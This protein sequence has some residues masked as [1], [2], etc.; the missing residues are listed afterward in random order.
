MHSS[1]SW[2]QPL[3][4]RLRLGI[5]RPSCYKNI[6]ELELQYTK[7]GDTTVDAGPHKTEM[8]RL[9]V[10]LHSTYSEILR[11]A[12]YRFTLKHKLFQVISDVTW[13]VDPGGKGQF[14]T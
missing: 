1:I 13:Q 8:H 7:T 3:N 12:I 10:I 14:V 11:A 5:V 9:H 6:K 2:S 4:W